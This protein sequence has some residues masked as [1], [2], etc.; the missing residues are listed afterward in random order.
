MVIP[1]FVRQA[2]AGEPLTVFGTGRA[3]A[4]LLPRA[5]RGPGA[6]RLIAADRACGRAVNLGSS[7]QVSIDGLAAR[8]IAATGS[9]SGI[10]RSSYL[11]A[12]GSGYED[13]QRR[14]PDC[15]LAADLVGFAR[16]P[17]AWTTSSRP[18]SR[19][20]SAGPARRRRERGVPGMSRPEPRRTATGWR[21]TRTAH[22]QPQARRQLGAG[23]PRRRVAGAGLAGRGAGRGAGAVA[24]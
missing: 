23:R 16:D 13:M 15:T 8:V 19:T 6:D 5:R 18:S 11:E 17:A 14:V 3:G 9:A 22:A 1:R 2:L 7:E 20:R 24:W 4:L 10:S 12:Y 21:A